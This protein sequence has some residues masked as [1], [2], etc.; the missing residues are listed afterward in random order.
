[1]AELKGKKPLDV[2]E[3]LGKP[4]TTYNRGILGK[5]L[6][7]M[8]YFNK[9]DAEFRFLRSSNQLESITINKPFD[10]EFSPEVVEEYG[11]NYVP[12]QDYDTSSYF[13]W[14]DLDGFSNV[15][16]YKVGMKKPDG[17]KTY[18]HIYFDFN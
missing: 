10:L 16:I 15:N 6:F 17:V 4:D 7:I 18:F 11:L 5:Q 2:E 9:R 12:T 1:V 14:K 8:R 3:I 13:R